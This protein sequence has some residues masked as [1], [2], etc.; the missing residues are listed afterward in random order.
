MEHA[1]GFLFNNLVA[2]GPTRLIGAYGLAILAGITTYL[3]S[4][5]V[6]PPVQ[7]GDQDDQAAQMAQVGSTMSLMMPLFIIF[8]S[9]AYKIALALVLY[10][11]ISNLYS[12]A[13]QYRVNG[14]GQ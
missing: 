2:F 9:F 8:I 5:M 6:T 12:I 14:W 3:Q 4:K 13:Q 11:T 1:L 10:W 7:P